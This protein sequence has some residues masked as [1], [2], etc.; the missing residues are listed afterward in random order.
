MP[1]PRTYTGGCH[2]GAVRFSVTMAIEAGVACNCSIC[3]KSATVLAFAPG[4]AFT[5]QSGQDDLVDY[6]FGQRRLHHLFCRRCGLRSFSRGAMPDGTPT[7]AINL[8]CVDGLDLAAIP[9]KAYD[10]KSIPVDG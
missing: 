10:G 8:R 2:C 6:Q 4:S 1:E 5:L 7:V 9:V 3:S